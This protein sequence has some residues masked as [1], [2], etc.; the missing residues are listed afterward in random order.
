MPI[1]VNM[2]PCTFNFGEYI[3]KE[4]EVPQGLYIVKSG[5]CK[6]ACRRIAERDLNKSDQ[7]QLNKKLGEKKRLKD[8][9]PLFNDFDTE[10]SILNVSIQSS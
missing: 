2:I 9:N 5:Q 3:I 6:V 1:A 4:G 7:Q 8:K 10:N